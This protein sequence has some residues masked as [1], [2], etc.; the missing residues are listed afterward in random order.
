MQF[1]AYS[2]PLEPVDPSLGGMWN[3]Q[4]YTLRTT[5]LSRERQENTAHCPPIRG[6]DTLPLICSSAALEAFDSL[7]MF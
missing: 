3:L 2:R 4:P 6:R 7:L 1:E 5:I